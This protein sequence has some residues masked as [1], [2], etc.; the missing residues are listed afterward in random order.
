MLCVTTCWLAPFSTLCLNRKV[1]TV[2]GAKQALDEAKAKQ[3]RKREM[4]LVAAAVLVGTVAVGLMA[5]SAA[6]A[7]RRSL[8]GVRSNGGDIVVEVPRRT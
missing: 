5:R 4:K 3:R 7:T 2:E 1:S 8:S 6:R